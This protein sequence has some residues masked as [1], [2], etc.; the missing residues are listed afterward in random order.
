MTIELKKLTEKV[1]NKK[2]F[3][4]VITKLQRETEDGYGLKD[5]KNISVVV[6]IPRTLGVSGTVETK[7]E[8]IEKFK[9]VTTIE[10]KETKIDYSKVNS[11]FEKQQNYIPQQPSPKTNTIKLNSPMIPNLIT[12]NKKK[13]R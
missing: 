9:V 10:K 2:Y 8:N 4:Q 12:R 11:V 1:P 13:L 5:D 6:K 3:N 7:K